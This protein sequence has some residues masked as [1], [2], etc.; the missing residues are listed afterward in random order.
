[1]HAQEVDLHHFHRLALH[2]HLMKDKEG[3]RRTKREG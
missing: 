1:M 2:H 3:Q